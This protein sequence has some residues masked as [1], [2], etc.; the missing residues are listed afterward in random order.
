M[1]TLLTLVCRRLPGARHQEGVQ[2]VQRLVLRH[3][4]EQQS[5]PPAQ[6]AACK[7]RRRD[8]Q[9]ERRRSEKI[10]EAQQCQREDL[11]R[12]FVQSFLFFR[13]LCFKQNLF[14]ALYQTYAQGFHG[15]RKIYTIQKKTVNGKITDCV[16]PEYI[17]CVYRDY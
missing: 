16:Y 7:I 9:S 17:L 10:F 8:S 2:P 15:Y 13:F 4:A 1:T 5:D 6:Q 3:E 14:Y 11:S 12:I